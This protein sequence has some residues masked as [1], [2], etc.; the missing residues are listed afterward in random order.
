[1]PWAYPAVYGAATDAWG[2]T[3]GVSMMTVFSVD[4]AGLSTTPIGTLTMTSAAFGMTFRGESCQSTDVETACDGRDNDG[5]G[6]VDEGWPDTD[7]DGKADCVDSE[8]CDGLDNDGDAQIDEGFDADGD[9]IADCFDVEECDCIDNNG[10]GQIDESCEH[11]VQVVAQADDRSALFY[12][13]NALGSTAGWSQVGTFTT[14]TTT[15]THYVSALAEDSSGVV[16]GFRAA[17]YV[18]GVLRTAT[19]DAG[20]LAETTNPGAGWQTNPAAFGD[21]WSVQGTCGGRWNTNNA[22]DVAGADW[23]WTGACNRPALIPRSWFIV[24]IE[25]C[26]R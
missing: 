7:G 17:V 21:P 13:G 11:F 2:N 9:G 24:P 14:S 6:L 23:I 25:I 5:D 16:V 10:D 12:D 26:P 20:W 15:G 19:G 8:Q 22:L 3:Y 1:M 18:D 4:I